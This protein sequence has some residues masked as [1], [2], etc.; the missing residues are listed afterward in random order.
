VRVELTPDRNLSG[1]LKANLGRYLPDQPWNA[2]DFSISRA[3][4][5]VALMFHDSGATATREK[6][7]SSIP[8]HYLDLTGQLALD[9]P[10]L[11]ARVDRPATRLVLGHAPRAPRIERTTMLRV[12][13]PLKAATAEAEGEGKGKDK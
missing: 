5:L 8:L 3:D 13:L 4:L 1:F 9:R 10:M 11:V 12:I 6:P 7:I 2:Q